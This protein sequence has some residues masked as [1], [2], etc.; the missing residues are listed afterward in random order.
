[1][2]NPPYLLDTSVLL[3][4]IED[5]AGADWIEQLLRTAP[6]LI[7]WMCVFEVTYST[8]QERD[9]TGTERRYARIKSLPVTHV[10]EHHEALLFTAARLKA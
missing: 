7:P 1:M 4:L 5:E 3:T 10:W 6:I 2:T 9:V 8:Q